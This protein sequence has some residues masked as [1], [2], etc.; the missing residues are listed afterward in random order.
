MCGNGRVDV[1]ER[2]GEKTDCESAVEIKMVFGGIKRGLHLGLE[3]DG[4]ESE[5]EKVS[6]RLGLPDEGVYRHDQER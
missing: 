2:C 3:D 1:D 4:V 5:K 6:G